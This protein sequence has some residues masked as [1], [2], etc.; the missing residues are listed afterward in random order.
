[1]AQKLPHMPFYPRDWR[2]DANL[3]RCSLEARGVWIEL[4]CLMWDCSDRG[5]LATAG[6]PWTDEEVAGAVGGNIDVV[7]RGIHELLAKGVASR[8]LGGAIFSRR[9]V[10]DEHVRQVRAQA[11]HLS[12]VAQA[13][14]R[15]KPEQKPDSDNVV[16]FEVPKDLEVY[17][18]SVRAWLEYKK[19][20]RQ[21]YKPSSLQ[22]LWKRMRA[23]GPDLPVL[24]ERAI[25]NQWQGFD[26][27]NG[28]KPQSRQ[29]SQQVEQAGKFHGR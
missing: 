13:K 27:G 24:L 28:A 3:R 19:S 15:A 11:G 9:M 25:A 2:G 10:H 14:P 22:A 18:D 17:G 16:A 8:N 20:R 26:F 29:F 5:V 6:V 21:S 1:M 4:L 23:A 7:I 12:Q